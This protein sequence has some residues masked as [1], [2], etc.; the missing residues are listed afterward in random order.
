M[1][2]EAGNLP[3][4]RSDAME[5]WMKSVWVKRLL[6]F[7]LLAV[8]WF[9]Y[10]WYSTR[11][12]A[13]RLADEHR[14][15]QATARVWIATAR[16]RLDQK[17]YL[18]YRDSLL[19]AEGLSAESLK[20]FQKQY[21]QTPDAALRYAATINKMVDSLVIREDSLLGIIRDT[22]AEE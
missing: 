10:D 15:A 21:E 3:F 6:P 8:L 22:T 13:S 11:R 20:A 17:G 2:T 4:L 14:H 1:Y 16:F 5:S 18:Q 7:V 9:G 19:A 12:E